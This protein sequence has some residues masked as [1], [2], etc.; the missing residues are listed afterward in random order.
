MTLPNHIEG[1]ESW[2]FLHNDTNKVIDEI[3]GRHPQTVSAAEKWVDLIKNRERFARERDLNYVTYIVP[4]KHCT[5]EN[6]LPENV[7]IS[8]QRLASRVKEECLESVIY[9]PEKFSDEFTFHRNDT[10]WSDSGAYIA[11]KDIMGQFNLEVDLKLIDSNFNWRLHVGDLSNREDTRK[12]PFLPNDLKGEKIFDNGILHVANTVVYQGNSEK[13]RSIIIFGGSSSSQIINY[14]CSE[15]SLVYRIW[16]QSIDWE[17][18]NKLGIKYVVSLPRERFMILPP[19]DDMSWDYSQTAALKFLSGVAFN[20]K[21]VVR[22][23]TLIPHQ[24]VELCVEV[25]AD[26]MSKM[27]ND[28]FSKRLATNPQFNQIGVEY[29]KLVY[30]KIYSLNSAIAERL[31]KYIYK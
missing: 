16:T 25:L 29:I 24:T 18:V 23:F 30:N 19:T 27:T 5:F 21:D 3:T 12:V 8:E 6:F 11:F 31:E 17:L 26:T 28:D 2:L 20:E 14:F 9:L 7:V 1:K 22:N 15:F 4:N 10:H 13:K